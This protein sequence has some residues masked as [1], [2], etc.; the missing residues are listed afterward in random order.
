MN[1]PYLEMRTAISLVTHTIELMA[2]A[3]PV[4]GR[5]TPQK[6]M[7][8]MPSPDSVWR[9]L[10]K[11]NLTKI[12]Q[13]QMG[14]EHVQHIHRTLVNAIQNPTTVGQLPAREG[15][16]YQASQK[17]MMARRRPSATKEGMVRQAHAI[18]QKKA[19]TGKEQRAQTMDHRAAEDLA[20]FFQQGIIPNE[21]FRAALFRLLKETPERS[22]Y[23]TALRRQLSDPQILQRVREQVEKLSHTPR[24]GRAAWQNPQRAVQGSRQDEGFTPHIVRGPSGRPRRRR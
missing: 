5:V 21:K 17:R 10:S 4:T 12:G 18:L 15:E 13:S 22:S 2:L 9:F 23:A 8:V 11:N 3:V 16:F 20:M 7:A 6:I 19:D 14:L 1:A 24:Q